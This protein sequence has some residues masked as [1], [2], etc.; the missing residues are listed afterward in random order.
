MVQQVA[1]LKMRIVGGMDPLAPQQLVNLLAS[2]T[3][4]MSLLQDMLHGELLSEVLGI[5]LWA[6]PPVRNLLQSSD[7]VYNLV[8]AQRLAGIFS[9]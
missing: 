5:S 2:L 7:V 4:C 9:P 6:C 3:G 8:Y 1:G